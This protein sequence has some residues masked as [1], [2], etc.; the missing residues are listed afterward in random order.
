MPVDDW[1]A[2]LLTA[3]RLDADQSPPPAHRNLWD[4]RDVAVITYGD[5]VLSETE[6]PLK[7]LHQFLVDRLGDLAYVQLQNLIYGMI[8][9]EF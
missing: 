8:M 5:S 1:V 3:A 7:S 6:A 9:Q 4:E 2:R